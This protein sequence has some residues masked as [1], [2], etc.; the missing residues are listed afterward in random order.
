MR[1]M[2]NGGI[3][4][5]RKAI[6]IAFLVCF[7]AAPMLS[8]ALILIHADHCHDHRHDSANGPCAVCALVG[9]AVNQLTQNGMPIPAAPY[10]PEDRFYVSATHKFNITRMDPSS[11]ITLRVKLNN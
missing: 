1:G 2:R 4:G 5:R 6:A 8:S 3:N 7:A 10:A 11:P 9:G